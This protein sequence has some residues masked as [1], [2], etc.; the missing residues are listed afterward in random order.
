[1]G[2]EHDARDVAHPGGA[3]KRR[4]AKLEDLHL[5]CIVL[6]GAT[7]PWRSAE[8]GERFREGFRGGYAERSTVV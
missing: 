1:M 8:T 6:A 2:V 3:A 5:R 7:R 4:A